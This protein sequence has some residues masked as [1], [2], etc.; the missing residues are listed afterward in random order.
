MPFPHML[1]AATAARFAAS[2]ARAPVAPGPVV[3]DPNFTMT[4]TGAPS[5]YHGITA[6]GAT[7]ETAAP[8]RTPAMVKAEAAR[9]GRLT[10]P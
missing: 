9:P 3:N 2:S 6:W 10:P 4:V 7:A 1:T 8:T 5:S